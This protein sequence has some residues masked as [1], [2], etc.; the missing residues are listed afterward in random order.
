MKVSEIKER[1]KEQIKELQRCL[2]S[3]DRLQEYAGKCAGENKEE[4]ADEAGMQCDM[5]WD[6]ANAL[7]IINKRLEGLRRCHDDMDRLWKHLTER[8]NEEGCSRM[9]EKLENDAGLSCPVSSLCMYTAG[10]LGSEI[11]RLE[12]MIGGADAQA[13]ANGKETTRHEG[14][15]SEEGD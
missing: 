8:E 9:L 15:G 11:R 10:A 2:D 7:Y 3:M 12:K 4:L 6:A 13:Q 1:I 5:C 14:M